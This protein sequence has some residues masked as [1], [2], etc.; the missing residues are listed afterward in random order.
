MVALRTSGRRL[1][2]LNLPLAV[3][4]MALLGLAPATVAL[5]AAYSGAEIRGRVTD[6]ETKQPLAGV[7]VVAQWILYTVRSPL[8]V[9]RGQGTAM[10]IMETVTDARGEYYVP[11]W[12]P[13]P[14]PPLSRFDW[15][16]DPILLFF[17]SGYQP[18]GRTNYGPPP[19]DEA[20]MPQRIS[21]WHGRT[22]TLEPFRGTARD[23]AIRLHT[24]QVQLGWADETDDDLHR[25]N[26]NWRQMPR[27]VLAVFEERRLLP[28]TLQYLVQ[29]L[30]TWRITE[31]QL[32]ASIKE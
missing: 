11:P 17:K 24:L 16:T 31:S 20:E 22:V 8:Q 19:D 23:R 5:P 7:H 15:G 1:G 32:R 6:A 9:H 4:E 13:K 12:G 29:D 10:Q 14:R 25:I 28:G 21:R 2:S 18:L 27:M 30:E 26:D 3:M